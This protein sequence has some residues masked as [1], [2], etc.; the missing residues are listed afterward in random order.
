[1]D[2]FVETGASKKYHSDCYEQFKSGATVFFLIS[3]S[4]IHFF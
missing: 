1:M 2:A 4:F 3:F